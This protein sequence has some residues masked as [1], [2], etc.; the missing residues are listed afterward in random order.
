MYSGW[1]GQGRSQRGEEWHGNTANELWNLL[2][3]LV[4]ASFGLVCLSMPFHWFLQ[5]LQIFSRSYSVYFCR[6]FP[7]FSLVDVRP[8]NGVEHNSSSKLVCQTAKLLSLQTIEIN[9]E[10]SSVAWSLRISLCLY[11]WRAVCTSHT[12]AESLMPDLRLGEGRNDDEMQCAESSG[13]RSVT[14]GAFGSTA[15]VRQ[16]SD[17]NFS[18]WTRL[19]LIQPLNATPFHSVFIAHNNIHSPSLLYFYLSIH[20]GWTESPRSA[21]IRNGFLLYL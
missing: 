3:C 5:A 11:G 19:Y 21:V 8:W 4:S 1:W 20:F 15:L 18:L 16:L 14:S 9:F 2:L 13:T 7:I 17:V 10:A 12:A 6:S